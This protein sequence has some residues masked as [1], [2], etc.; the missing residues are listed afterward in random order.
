MSKSIIIIG[1]GMRALPTKL[2]YTKECVSV[3]SEDGRMFYEYYDL[4]KFE[5]HLC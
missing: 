4:E 1:P 3:V 2:I 5:K